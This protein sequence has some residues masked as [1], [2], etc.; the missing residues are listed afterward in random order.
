MLLSVLKTSRRSDAAPFVWKFFDS[1]CNIFESFEYGSFDKFHKLAVFFI[2]LRTFE[3]K[4][5]LA[6]TKAKSEKY[7]KIVS[8]FLNERSETKI[9]FVFLSVIAKYFPT[10]PNF[11]YLQPKLL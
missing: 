3:L 10:A 6:R 1:R 8:K 7:L 4:I 5:K 9:G 11:F 2:F